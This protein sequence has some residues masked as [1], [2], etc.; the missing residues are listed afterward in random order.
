[1]NITNKTFLSGFEPLVRFVNGD[2]GALQRF[3]AMQVDSLIPGTGVR[4]ILN[5][6]IAPQLKD[7][8]ANFLQY[9]ANRN[10]W[11]PPVNSA[12]YDLVD[13][14][15]GKPINYIDP[16]N[17]AVNSLLPF[18][19]T[20]GGSEEWRQKLLESGWDNLNTI[21]TNPISGQPLS[22]EER[23]FVNNWIGE[24]YGLDKKMEEF[25]N[26]NEGQVEKELKAYAKKRG[27]KT[28]AQYPIRKTWMHEQL[29]AIHSEAFKAGFAALQTQR[30]DLYN[31]GVLQ[32]ATE[33]MIGQGNYGGAADAT[34]Q[35]L[36]MPK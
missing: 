34:Q 36:N 20:N 21:R 30:S 14:Y 7:V 1:M 2:P 23:N 16:I 25:F 12:L 29:D 9:L 27:L 19:K 6:A 13:V 24:N 17:A 5:K 28:Q 31:K 3:A 8:E 18:F 4:S 26:M 32:K 22:P 11:L 33:D 35:I 15:G 10:K